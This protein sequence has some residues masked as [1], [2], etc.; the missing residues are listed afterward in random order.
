ML[1]RSAIPLCDTIVV[2]LMLYRPVLPPRKPSRIST[3]NVP[4]QR[5]VS[6]QPGAKFCV[7]RVTSQIFRDIC[8]TS[9]LSS[10]CMKNGR[11]YGCG[12]AQRRVG[13]ELHVREFIALEQ[14]LANR[15]LDYACR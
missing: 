9:V 15:L 3:F 10:G 5:L 7:R 13:S 14:R 11:K 8:G 12:T 2:Y 6:H 1:Y 4:E